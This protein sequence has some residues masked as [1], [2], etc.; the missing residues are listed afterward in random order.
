MSNAALFDVHLDRSDQNLLA[1][2]G[3]GAAVVRKTVLPAK[4]IHAVLL[5]NL[6]AFDKSPP[7]LDR[8]EFDVSEDIV[9]VVIDCN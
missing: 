1:R 3:R 5:E 6:G 8:P 9:E 4:Q 2:H 7:L